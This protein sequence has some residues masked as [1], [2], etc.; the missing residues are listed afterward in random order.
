MMC[1]SLIVEIRAV[2][3]LHGAICKIFIH[4]YNWNVQRLTTVS[5]TQVVMGVSQKNGV[6]VDYSSKN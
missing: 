1:S 5:R 6:D 3:Q 4:H 2:N